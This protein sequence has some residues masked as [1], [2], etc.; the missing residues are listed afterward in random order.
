MKDKSKQFII[1]HPVIADPD[2]N[3]EEWEKFWQIAV[4][5]TIFN[6]LH[7]LAECNRWRESRISLV[8]RNLGHTGVAVIAT[9][10]TSDF[11]FPAASGFIGKFGVGY[12]L[13]SERYKINFAFGDD[14]FCK[15]RAV[16]TAY[17]GHRDI[18]LL[19]DVCGILDVYTVWM[20]HR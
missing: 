6:R 11:V 9:Q 20:I 15:F 16:N 13:P 7:H 10:T 18:C 3:P 12:Q 1:Q 5:G 4:N 14:A 2:I 17:Y 8:T 19:F